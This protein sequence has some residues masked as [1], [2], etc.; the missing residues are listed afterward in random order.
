MK[1]EED[2]RSRRFAF[3]SFC[4]ICQA[5]QAQGI[6]K[7]FPAII[8]PV[9]DILTGSHINIIQM[10]CPESTFGS[11][12]DSLIRQPQGYQRYNTPVFR[13]HCEGIAGQMVV[14][15]KSLIQKGYEVVVI[16]GIENSPSCAVNYQWEGRTVHRSGVFTQ[17]LHERLLAESLLIPF[18]GVNRYGTGPAE[19]AL[20]EILKPQPRLVPE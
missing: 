3:V 18:V 6:V 9:T 7:K 17:V 8:K 1:C 12:D 2:I 20:M 13:A 19:K 4:L 14:T 5:F 10:P 16:I 11:L 15:M